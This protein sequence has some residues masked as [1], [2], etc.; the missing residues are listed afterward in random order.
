MEREIKSE[1]SISLLSLSTHL[2][3]YYVIFY[4][5]MIIYDYLNFNLVFRDI[6]EKY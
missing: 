1:D 2:K 3:M 6:N 5:K 4:E